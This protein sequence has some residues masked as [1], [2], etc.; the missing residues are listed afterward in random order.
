MPAAMMMTTVTSE[1]HDQPFPDNNTSYH[2]CIIPKELP[3]LAYWMMGSWL[4]PDCNFT[5]PQPSPPSLSPPNTLQPSL[6]SVTPGE[7]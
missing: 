1:L 6:A 7:S 2:R 5:V 4:D 3:E